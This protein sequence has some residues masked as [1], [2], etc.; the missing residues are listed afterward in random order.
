MSPRRFC[1]RADAIPPSGIR[2]FF[3]LVQQASD[4]VISLGVGEPDFVTPWAFSEAAIYGIEH[5]YTTY[6]AN[7]GMPELR[8]QIARYYEERYGVAYRAEDEILV[9][10]G[11][12]EAID[13]A[14]RT[15]LNPGDEVIIPEPTFI[16][17]SPLV[18]LAGGTP[19]SLDTSGTEFIP[20]PKQLA[21]QITD[22]TVAIVLC[23]PNNPTGR[24][25]PEAVLSDIAKLAEK[26]DLWVISDEI[27]AE[28][29]YDM[30]FR[31]FAALKKM[32][33]RTITVN[34]FSKAF[35]MTGWRLGYACGP[36]AF[37]ERALKIHQYGMMCASVMAQLAGIEALKNG[38]DEVR[39][40]VA[41]YHRRRNLIVEG[42]NRI[43]MPTLMPEGA[44]Y[45]FPSI[46]A[47][48]LSSEDFAMRL[49]ESERVAAV[50]GHVFGAGGEGF[51]RCSY[52]TGISELKSALE[53]IERFLGTLTHAH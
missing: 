22:R 43:G 35:A 48:G 19:V 9:T 46:Q 21:A 37:I 36:S 7:R 2:R 8:D 15:I 52:A 10:V 32:K 51:L 23:S 41:S 24:V 14:F 42:F 20:D 16:C 28:I 44:F 30:E 17:Y 11:G 34:G 50:P 45:C 33:D 5:G 39:Q 6:T 27:Y 25:I 26:H 18:T 40:M 3:D 1:S 13:L 38:A 53:R 49:F 4:G 12:S 29:I 31:A 47:T